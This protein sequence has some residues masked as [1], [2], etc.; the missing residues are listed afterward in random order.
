[1]LEVYVVMT[2]LGV[3]YFLNQNRPVLTNQTRQINVN[4]MPVSRSIYDSKFFNTAKAIEQQKTD[5]LFREQQRLKSLRENTKSSVATN[6][7]GPRD[8]LEQQRMLSTL[9]GEPME[10]THKNMIPFFKGNIK[11][12]VKLDANRG[13]LENFTGVSDLYKKKQEREPLF[14]L[15]KDQITGM[16]VQTD[17]YMSNIQ[18]PRIQNNIVPIPQ[19]RVGKGVGQGFTSTPV[20]GFQQFS[21]RDAVMPKTVDELRKGSNPK[22]TFEGRIVDGQKPTKR[23][24][25][26]PMS[27]NRACTFYETGPMFQ[28]TGAYTKAAPKPEYEAKYTTRVDTSVSYK[29][30]PYIKTGQIVQPN[31]KGTDK[32]QLDSFGVSNAIIKQGTGA[33]DDYGKT[34]IQVYSNERDITTERTYQGNIT[35]IVKAIIA[36][37]QDILKA[38]RKEYMVDN[39]RSFG[40]L[41]HQGPAK[42]TIGP[43]DGMRTTIKESLLTE[44]DYTNV[45]GGAF[46]GVV[47]DPNDVARTTIKQ[48]TIDAVENANLKGP[49]GMSVYDPNNVAR[50]TIKETMIDAVENAN[51]KGPIGMSVYDPNDVAR[52]TIKQTTIDAVENANLKGPIGM[53]VYDPN[54]IARTTI[55]QTTIDAVENANLKGPIRITV[56]DPNEIARLTLKQTLLSETDYTNVKGGA[57]KGVAYDPNDIARTTLKQTLIHDSDYSNIDTGRRGA[58]ARNDEN[59]KQTIRETMQNPDTE[60]NMAVKRFVS[61]AYD[62][63]DVARTTIKQTMIDMDRSGNVQTKDPR[64]AYIDVEMVAKETNQTQLCDNDYIGQASLS[65]NDGYK[66]APTDI[67][68]T[69]KEF[70]SDNDYF[71]NAMDQSSHVPM[72][73]EDM[74][75]ACIDNLKED[76]EEG[77]EPTTTGVKIANGA[78]NMT[79]ES[80][81]NITDG[82]RINDLGKQPNKPSYIEQKSITRARNE[83]TIDDRLEDDFLNV[84]QSNP[85]AQTPLSKQ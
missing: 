52:T 27:K 4:E 56:Y 48:T 7:C 2:L 39:P 64:G 65:M 83:Y 17:R 44:T 67:K 71:G 63:N 24:N 23:A 16:P 14:A 41:Q 58:Q 51:L 61:E 21:E 84:L 66:T 36:P 79:V 13:I 43:V 10:M 72:S 55:K 22:I 46:K 30:A 38:N 74:Y 75:N 8:T 70:L 35:S 20:G 42:T 9:T 15:E 33:K 6:E 80:R 3:G 5:K 85:Y 69:Q 26:T 40:Q 45:K 29:G 54:N 31:V 60:L 32:V 18:A 68:V 34:N 53:S 1:M 28:T 59:A 81:K 57:R 76:L 50:T 62:P 47:H 78:D 25:V 19:I 77:R 37:I 49:I 82:S 11:Q 73:Y 12:S